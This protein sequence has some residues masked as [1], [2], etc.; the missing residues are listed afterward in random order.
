M[1]FQAFKRLYW[2]QDQYP[3]NKLFLT[4]ECR[5]PAWRSACRDHRVQQS[6]CSDQCNQGVVA[7]AATTKTD[8]SCIIF[9]SK[10]SSSWFLGV[11][12]Q[13]VEFGYD[14]KPLFWWKCYES[15]VLQSG[16]CRISLFFLIV[17]SPEGDLTLYCKGADTILYE[18]L[19]PSCD[20]L[21]EETTEHLNVSVFFCTANLHLMVAFS[22]GTEM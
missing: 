14:W 13:M 4:F 3:K 12:H 5:C 10:Q 15:W 16:I 7:C 22:P 19:H 21:K 20:S 2:Q 9:C 11:C 6:I 8:S 17:R 18:L 1:A